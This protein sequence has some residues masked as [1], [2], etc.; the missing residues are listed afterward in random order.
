MPTQI[1]NGKP[2]EQYTPE[3]YA[4]QQGDTV[5]R[6]GVAGT[7]AGRGEANYLAELTPSLAGLYA[8]SGGGGSSRATSGGVPSTVSY[9]GGQFPSNARPDQVSSAGLTAGTAGPSSPTATIAP[10]D[11]SKANTAAFATAKDQAAKTAQASLLGLNQALRARGFGG[12][13]YEA[14]QIGNTLANVANSVGEAGRSEA[15]HEADLGARAAE[16][17]L[18][19]SVAQRGQD[20]GERQSSADR[21]LRGAEAAFSGGISQRGQ[22]MGADEAAAA[23]DAARADA[24]YSG[25]IAQRGQDINA[26]EAAANLAQSQATLKSQQTLAILRQVLGA[27]NGPSPNAGQYVY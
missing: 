7:A 6:Q 14:G 19:A 1:I 23:R 24:A 4:A 9:P 5:Q 13:G 17:N 2:F 26:A 21:S 20:I 11:F 8:A 25:S 18:N 27:G 10:V 12:A 3:W 16:D 15:V 22:N